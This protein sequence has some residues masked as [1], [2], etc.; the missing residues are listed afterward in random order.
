MGAK[1]SRS[2]R[3]TGHPESTASGWMSIF[4]VFAELIARGEDLL[5]QLAFMGYTLVIPQWWSLSTNGSHV[6]VRLV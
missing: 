5:A 2:Q 4:F 6:T 3:F 1:V